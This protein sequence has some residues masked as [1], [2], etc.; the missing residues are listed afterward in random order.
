MY[1]YQL[2]NKILTSCHQC[3]PSACTQDLYT[4]PVHKTFAQDLYTRPV[5]N[6]T[7]QGNALRPCFHIVPI[8]KKQHYENLPMQYTE[9]FLALKIENFQFDIFLIF[10]QNLRLCVHVRTASPT[11]I[12]NLCFGAKIRKIGLPRQTSVFLYKRVGL[13]GV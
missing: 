3:V 6:V 12:H 7:L 13:K 9:I 8:R 4:R 1:M 11:C 2:N 5:H 10:A